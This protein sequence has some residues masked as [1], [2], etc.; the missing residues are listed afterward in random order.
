MRWNSWRLFFHQRKPGVLHQPWPLLVPAPHWVPARAL[1]RATSAPQHHLLLW[2]LQR[3]RPVS[4]ILPFCFS[5]QTRFTLAYHSL[6]CHFSWTRISI[7]L[8]NAALTE[9]TRFRWKQSG[10]RTGNIWSIDNGIHFEVEIEE[11][12]EIKKHSL[13]FVLSFFFLSL[14]YVG[15]AC[16]RFCSGRGH[17]SRTGCKWEFIIIKS[18]KSKMTFPCKAVS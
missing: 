12:S 15:P 3:V 5:L 11:L 7:P 14:V 9:T 2:Q 10:T 18:N 17:C 8:P 4:T 6:I 1:H 16:L 13:E